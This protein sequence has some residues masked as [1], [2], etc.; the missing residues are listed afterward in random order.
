MDFAENYVCKSNEEIQSAYW[1]MTAVTLHPIVVYFMNT[2]A[3]LE[4]VSFVVVSD[5][6]S[7]SAITVHAIKAKRS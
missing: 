2:E 3:K 7:H 4:H 5:E 6:I 1:N